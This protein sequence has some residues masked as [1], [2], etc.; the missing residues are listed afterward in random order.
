MDSKKMAEG[1]APTHT[2]PEGRRMA[3]RFGR[4]A[5]AARAASIA[6]S[7]GAMIFIIYRFLV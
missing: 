4:I 3:R 2:T 6:V 5:M 1:A 7:L